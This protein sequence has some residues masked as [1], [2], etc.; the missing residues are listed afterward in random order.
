MAIKKTITEKNGVQTE[1]HKIKDL[2][3]EDTFEDKYTVEVALA[4]YVNE[5]VR[6]TSADNSAV[7]RNISLLLPAEDVEATSIYALV[8]AELKKKSLFEGAEDC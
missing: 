1:Y 2:R 6:K 3:I 4:S 8:Y 5:D 7:K